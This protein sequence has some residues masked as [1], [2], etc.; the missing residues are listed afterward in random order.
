MYNPKS[1]KA[2]RQAISSTNKKGRA[3]LQKM[4]TDDYVRDV[5]SFEKAHSG[6]FSTLWVVTDIGGIHA[7]SIPIGGSCE[8]SYLGNIEQYF[9][10]HTRK[11]AGYH[12][13]GFWS[14]Q[15]M[16]LH[17]M[18]CWLKRHGLT[19]DHNTRIINKENPCTNRNTK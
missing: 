1:S 10:N 12:R 3:W 5:L 13:I 11:Y 15:V 8:P 16:W 2:Y 4:V 6:N 9:Q 18:R 14:W 7:Y 19:V 17:R